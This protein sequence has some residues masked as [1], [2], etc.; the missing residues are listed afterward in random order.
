MSYYGYS[1][2]EREAYDYEFNAEYDRFDG[3]DD[4]NDAQEQAYDDCIGCAADYRFED[5]DGF[6]A[7]DENKVQH[8][9]DDGTDSRDDIPF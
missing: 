3:R 9:Y 7:L 6:V 4:I 5:L 8:D 2:Q 1:E